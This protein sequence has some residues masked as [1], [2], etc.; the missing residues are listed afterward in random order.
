[1]LVLVKPFI[2]FNLLLSGLHSLGLSLKIYIFGKLLSDF[3]ADVDTCLLLGL[4]QLG[5]ILLL[6][7]FVVLVYVWIP[8]VLNH[9]LFHAESVHELVQNRAKHLVIRH[10]F[11]QVQFIL[12]L[13]VSGERNEGLSPSDLLSVC[14]L[15]SS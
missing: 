14:L 5:G 7:Q 3:N 4:A 8:F 13:D 11:L 1:M 12:L 6:A 15:L 10:Q 2:Q 9:R